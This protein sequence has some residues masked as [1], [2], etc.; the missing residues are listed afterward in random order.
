MASSTTHCAR[1]T[2]WLPVAQTPYHLF[3]LY[4][5]LASA[6]VFFSAASRAPKV[7]IGFAFEGPVFEVS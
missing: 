6:V 5:V 2:L 4:A 7:P 1:V 3:A